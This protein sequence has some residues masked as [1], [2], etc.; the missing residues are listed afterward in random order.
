MQKKESAKTNT[1][2][3]QEPKV[4]EQYIGAY[5]NIKDIVDRKRYESQDKAIRINYNPDEDNK[6]V[7]IKGDYTDFSRMISNLLNNGV[8]AVEEKGEEGKGEVEVSYEVKGEEVEVI[9]KDNGVGMPKEKV[10]KIN[11]GEAVGTSKEMGN[12]IGMEEIL[13]VV[14]EL[15]GKMEVGSKEGEGTEF[16]LR[17]AKCGKPKWF[18]DKIEIKKGSTVVILDDDILVH[19]MWKE[20]FKGYEKEKELEVKYFTDVMEAIKYINSKEEKEREKVFLLTDYKFKGE[21]IN[22]IVVIEKTNMYD[23]HILVTSQYLSE[24][25]NFNEKT[26]TVGKMHINDVPLVLI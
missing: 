19:E 9:V 22:G 10:E 15:K 14:K 2:E 20:R 6:F 13:R 5:N 21:S 16:R 3:E 1:Q 17:F 11:R 23:R 18:A 12:G 26:K 24:M 7:F 25:K 8:E 4:D